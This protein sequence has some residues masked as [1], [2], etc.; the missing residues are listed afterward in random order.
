MSEV[1]WLWTI[2]CYD[3]QSWFTHKE[4]QLGEPTECPVCLNHNIRVEG[5]DNAVVD[6]IQ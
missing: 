5:G 3:C 1:F 6:F 2:L 4:Y